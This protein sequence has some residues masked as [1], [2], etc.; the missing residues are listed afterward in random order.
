MSTSQHDTAR[1]WAASGIPVFP[2]VPN[3]KA[4]TCTH[5][6][7]DATTDPGQIEAWIAQ[8]PNCNWAFTPHSV[9]W[10]VVDLDGEEGKAA[11]VAREKE[12]GEGPDTYLVQTP[13]DGIHIYFDGPLPTT[14]WTPGNT[15]CIGEHIDTRGVG[16]YVLLP[17]SIVDGK[18][19]TV[20]NDVEIAPLPAWCQALVAPRDNEAGAAVEDLDLPGNVARGRSLLSACAERGDVAISGR[21]GN[22]RSY[23]LACE[24]LNLGLTPGTALE[25]LLDVWNP[26]CEPPWSES[27]LKTIVDNAWRYMQNEAGAWGV[28]PASEVFRDVVTIEHTDHLNEHKRSRFYFE[29]EVEQ[30]QGRDPT[31]IIKDVIPEQ[32]TVLLVGKTGSYKSFLA[33]DMLLSI[34]TG[35]ETFG[36]LPL[37]GPTF[38]GAMEGRN[39]IKKARRRAWKAARGMDAPISEFYVGPA[40][41]IGMPGEM[42]EFGDE[43]KRR[44]Q[45]E[46][47]KLIVLDTL[48]KCMAGLNENDAGDA[49]RFIRFCDSLVE[50]FGC[51]VIA[52][53]HTGKD[54]GR[55]ARGSSAFQA[56]FD[57]VLECKAH[58]ATKS[59]EVWVRKHKDAEEREAPFTFQGKEVAGSL[60]FFPTDDSTHRTLTAA[61]DAWAP[62]KIGAALRELNSFGRDQGVTTRVLAT[63]LCPP[64]QDESE[65]SR[66]RNLSVAERALR[67]LVKTRLAGYCERAGRE[68]LWFLPT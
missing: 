62:T 31:W 28:E 49:G 2:C 16:S 25:L 51:S 55:G 6:F 50:A 52:I 57:T 37:T 19:Y 5:G 60:V 42:Q 36:V 34:S 13:R 17:G 11:W 24:I 58:R 26:R 41:I 1:Q 53:H 21:G 22:S 64:V 30:E 32:S 67:G 46:R 39:S 38:Y 56:G 63:A 27:E 65:E 18:P 8:W 9:G 54:E 47:P 7:H 33:L 12:Y 43:I 45:H 44:C 66:E 14:A 3:G 10:S 68:L 61:N 59:V 48:S 40:P 20:I 35:T 29:D 15:R 23:Q 4:P